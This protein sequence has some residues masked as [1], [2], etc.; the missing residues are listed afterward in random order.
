[1]KTVK[2]DESKINILELS[3]ILVNL[4]YWTSRWQSGYGSHL[5]NR[6]KYWEQKADVWV[7]LNTVDSNE[8]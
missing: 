3:E 2:I 6:K 1:M 5:A 8:V 7:K 4:R